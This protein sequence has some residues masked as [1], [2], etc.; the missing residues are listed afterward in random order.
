MLEERALDVG[1]A[2][3]RTPGRAVVRSGATFW[4]LLR[5]ASG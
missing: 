2:A 5:F 1:E 4:S 3:E